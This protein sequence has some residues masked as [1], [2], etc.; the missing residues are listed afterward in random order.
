MRRKQGVLRTDSHKL[1]DVDG[2]GESTAEKLRDAGIDRPEDLTRVTPA[3]LEMID[4]IGPRTTE[5]LAAKFQY[6]QTRFLADAG[7]SNINRPKV[8]VK[9]AERS[10][11][12][13]RTD[14]SFNADITVDDEEWIEDPDR[15][16]YPG[17]DTVPEQRRAERVKEKVRDLDED[18]EIE[19]TRIKGKATGRHMHGGQGPAKIEVDIQDSWD[20]VSSA[21]HEVGHAVDRNV[22][23][24]GK[25][26][27]KLFK[28]NNEETKQLR[29]E[30]KRLTERRRPWVDDADDLVNRGHYTPYEFDKELLADAWA[31][32][33]EEPKA[34]R[35]EAPNLIDRIEDE[36]TPD[37]SPF[38]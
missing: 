13:R 23:E 11:A 26:S 27:G 5:R 21:A 34:A 4:G 10:R 31:V 38:G 6:R 2:I 19:P 20:P 29:E 25:L 7:A 15:H 35:R 12:A 3:Q 37:I 16:D 33:V 9:M 18:V 22:T 14:R 36:M 24:F 1:T 17:I 32:G 28:G 30:A 8:R